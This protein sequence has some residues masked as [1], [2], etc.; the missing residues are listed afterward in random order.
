MLRDLATKLIESLM[1]VEIRRLP[2]SERQAS[3]GLTT[4]FST[5]VCTLSG[6]V[7]TNLPRVLFEVSTYSPVLSSAVIDKGIA[8]M[9]SGKTTVKY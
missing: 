8:P 4:S 3:D 9:H 2:P 1:K 7:T 5:I 6:S